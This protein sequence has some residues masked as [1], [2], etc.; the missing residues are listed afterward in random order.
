M[1]PDDEALQFARDFDPA[2]P[3]VTRERYD[4][5]LLE[6]SGLLRTAFD[7]LSNEYAP[8]DEELDAW[9]KPVQALISVNVACADLR[10]ESP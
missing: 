8:T 7:W 6:T 2:E 5:L 10:E 4:A 3:V 1:D 9:G